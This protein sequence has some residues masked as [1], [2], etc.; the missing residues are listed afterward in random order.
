[1]TKRNSELALIATWTMG[2]DPT[3]DLP[4]SVKWQDGALATVSDYLKHL[5]DTF[6]WDL[7][8]ADGPRRII[9]PSIVAT[10]SY[11]QIAG[12]WTISGHGVTR[13]VL[14]VSD[15]HATDEEIALE[16]VINFA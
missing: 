12:A 3:V 10:A 6:T 16:P 8:S 5:T 13:A 7:E 2:Q 9:R 4:A 14:D 15:P 11:D 1:M